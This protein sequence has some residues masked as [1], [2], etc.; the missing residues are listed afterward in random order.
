MRAQESEQRR[1][2]SEAARRR[3]RIAIAQRT[4]ATCDSHSTRRRAVFVRV[5]GGWENRV[6]L[7]ELG[8]RGA[9][10]RAGEN[11]PRLTC[12][13]ICRDPEQITPWIVRQSEVDGK[14]LRAKLIKRDA[15]GVVKVSSAITYIIDL[16][17]FWHIDYP[18][19][20][21]NVSNW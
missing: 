3:E 4:E 7:P 19:E 8:G 18:Q 9:K 2:Q 14:E 21:K 17:L 1:K 16:L 10:I 5:H 20:S 11:Y 12:N 6:K 13:F 15:T